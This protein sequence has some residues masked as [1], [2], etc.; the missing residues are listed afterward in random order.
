MADAYTF[1]D[2]QATMSTAYKSA[3]AVEGV[4]TTRGRIYEYILGVSG[5]HADAVIDWEVSRSST[6]GTRTVGTEAEIDTDGPAALLGV[7]GNH[8]AEGTA[9]ANAFAFQH[10]IN[11]RVTYRVVLP[12]DREIVI[13][14]TANSCVRGRAQHLTVTSA[15]TAQFFWYE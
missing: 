1:V 9:I 11:D 2:E 10:S 6:T 3:A 4:T 13:P 12:P 5:A 14:A 8:T 7:G 15:F